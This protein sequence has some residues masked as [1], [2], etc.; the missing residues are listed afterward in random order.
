[1]KLSSNE[2]KDAI[3][4]N[5]LNYRHEARPIPVSVIKEEKSMRKFM[6]A[7]TRAI[8]SFILDTPKS[9]EY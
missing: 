3:K 9:K 4:M 8:A 6:V 2:G 1:V 5:L 7:S